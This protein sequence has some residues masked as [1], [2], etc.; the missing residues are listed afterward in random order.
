MKT[1][2]ATFASFLGLA[3]F[4]TAA[5]ALQSR[6][7]YPVCCCSSGCVVDSVCTTDEILFDDGINYCCHQNLETAT[8]VEI[9]ELY[10]EG[11]CFVEPPEVTKERLS[12]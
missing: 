8:L 1:F 4:A 7:C 9:A 10:A 2:L 5:P 11:Q 3:V 12:E 6:W